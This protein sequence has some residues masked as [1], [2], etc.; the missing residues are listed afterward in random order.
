VIVFIQIPIDDA[1]DDP[2][3]GLIVLSNNFRF[4]QKE[5]SL[6]GVFISITLPS[7]LVDKFVTERHVPE[8]SCLT[9]RAKSILVFVKNLSYLLS[10]KQMIRIGLAIY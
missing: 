4:E 10:D 2:F 1:L 9:W 7:N 8:S 6:C 5:N 3:V